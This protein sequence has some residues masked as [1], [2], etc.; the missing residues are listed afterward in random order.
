MNSVTRDGITL[1]YD[2]YGQP[3][4]SPVLLL[5]G[6]G[7]DH[8]MWAPQIERYPREEL[9]LIAPD[10]RGHGESDEV[11][12]FR[13]E[14]CADDVADLLD[15]LGLERVAVI[16]VSM[17]GLIAQQLA[18]THPDRVSTLILADTFSGV[19]GPLARLNARAAEIGLSLLPGMWQ[20]KI[21]ESHYDA[22]EQEALR[23]YFETMLFR[24]DADQLKQARRAV[25][26]FDCVEELEQIDAPTLVLVGE[27]NG[28]W[29]VNLSR[30]TA[31]G[32]SEAVFTVL[33][34]GVDPSNLSVTEAFDDAVLE[35]LELA[36][37]IKA[38]S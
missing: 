22:P 17:G 9:F 25:N 6:L 37:G 1:A 23:E 8:E 12:E 34:D 7:A 11:A 24:T 31:D 33:P 13:I 2:T 21:I 30:R 14:D 20:W 15:D 26:R 32:I 29:F 36:S 5:H 19:R 35:F 38:G 18:I 27:N 10:M 3:S 28:T 16:G 4:D